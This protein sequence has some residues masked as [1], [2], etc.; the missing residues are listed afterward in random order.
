M[1][2]PIGASH[3]TIHDVVPTPPFDQITQLHVHDVLTLGTG[4]VIGGVEPVPHV[5][6]IT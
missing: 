4:L 2:E 5:L 6:T 1:I 3:V